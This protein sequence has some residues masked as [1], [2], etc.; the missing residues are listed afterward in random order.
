MKRS[1]M[2]FNKHFRQ[3]VPYPTDYQTSRSG[4][5]I[6]SFLPCTSNLYLIDTAVKEYLGI[7]FYKL[8]LH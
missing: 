5:D 6:L 7:I 1:Y 8:T 3:I 4:Y 2:L